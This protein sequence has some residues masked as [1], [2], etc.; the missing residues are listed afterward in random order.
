[1][2]LQVIGIDARDEGLE[3]TRANGADVV[4]DARK[5]KDQVVQEVHRV[6]NGE[7]ADATCNVS[8]AKTAAALACAVTKTHGKMIQ[9]RS[10]VRFP[11]WCS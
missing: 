9:V 1:M 2:G 5:G 8:D 11:E 4:I 10:L 7:G 3:L 6:T